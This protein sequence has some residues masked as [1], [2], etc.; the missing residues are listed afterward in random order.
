MGLIHSLKSRIVCENVWF[1]HKWSQDKCR[2][3]TWYVEY[4]PLYDKMTNITFECQWLIEEQTFF[5]FP[6]KTALFFN[7]QIGFGECYAIPPSRFLKYH[8]IYWFKLVSNSIGSPIRWSSSRS[9]D[10]HIFTVIFY[11]FHGFQNWEMSIWREPKWEY[12]LK[13]ENSES[14]H[15]IMPIYRYNTTS[16]RIVQFSGDFLECGGISLH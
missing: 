11:K 13:W 15:H 2:C 9:Y 1:W 6:K 3:D 10:I 7:I 5:F 16:P 12:D 14:L 8:S 4:V